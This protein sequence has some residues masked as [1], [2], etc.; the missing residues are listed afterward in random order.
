MLD[1]YELIALARL[2][3]NH[4]VGTGETRIEA[5]ADKLLDYAERQREPTPPLRLRHA[6][7]AFTNRVV[8]RVE[9]NQPGE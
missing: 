5:I 7:H 2:L 9:S 3:G 1:H 6:T 4:V 8:F